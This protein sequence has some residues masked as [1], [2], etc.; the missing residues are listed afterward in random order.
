MR[1]EVFVAH[2]R[3]YS[4]CVWEKGGTSV[5]RPRLMWLLPSRPEPVASQKEA[6]TIRLL[7]LF[8]QL[9]IKCRCERRQRD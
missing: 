4:G 9:G 2:F 7:L 3:Y 6:L 8:V 5:Q 1:K